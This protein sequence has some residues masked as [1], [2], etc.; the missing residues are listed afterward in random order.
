MMELIIGVIV[1]IGTI[2]AFIALF[3]T[4]N[5]KSCGK[6]RPVA[7][8]V[9]ING[10]KLVGRKCHDCQQQDK[11]KQDKVDDEDFSILFKTRE[12]RKKSKVNK[13]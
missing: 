9:R 5:C 1:G 3:F 2:L 12:E 6:H 10:Q 7:E 13:S 11:K 8:I 4:V